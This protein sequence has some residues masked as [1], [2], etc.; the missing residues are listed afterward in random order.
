MVLIHDDA[1]QRHHTWCELCNGLDYMIR[2][3]VSGRATPKDFHCDLPAIPLLERNP[4]SLVHI[5]RRC[6]MRRPGDERYRQLLHRRYFEE[7]RGF[8]VPPA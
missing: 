2:E 1:E 7:R 4:I 3:K 5:Q 6:G 8:A